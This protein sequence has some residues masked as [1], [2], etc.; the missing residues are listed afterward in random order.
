MNFYLFG[1]YWGKH[2]GRLF[3]LVLVV[4]LLTASSVFA[5]LNERSELRRQLNRL[6]DMYGNYSLVLHGVSDENLRKIEEIPNIDSLFEI[7]GI[8]SVGEVNVGDAEY[9]VGSFDSKESEKY[10]NLPLKSGHLPEKS[11]EIAVP[12]FIL[13]KISAQTD[14][15]E[16]ISLNFTDSSGKKTVLTGILSGI[17]SDNTIREDM[18]Y[19]GNS[20]GSAVVGNEVEFPTPS[21]FIYYEDVQNIAENAEKYENYILVRSD[22]SYFSDEQEKYDEIVDK[23]YEIN[24]NQSSGKQYLILSML[25]QNSGKSENLTKTH[26]KEVLSANA[27]GNANIKIIRAMSLTMM[28]ISAI[29]LISGVSAV[30]PDR[31][32]SLKLLR[33]VGMSKKKL[34]SL[35]VT[36]FMIFWIIGN[37]AGIFVG[38]LLHGVMILTEQK[39][40]IQ[41]FFGYTA[42][43]IV[44]KITISPFLMPVL[45][46]AVVAVFSAIIPVTNIFR[47]NFSGQS[48][49]RRSKRGLHSET[50]SIHGIFGKIAGNR[51]LSALSCVSIAVTICAVT[52]GYCYFTADG[53]GKTYLTIGQENSQDE[54]FRI[55]GVD[56]RK[57]DI[58]CVLESNIPYGNSIAVYDENFGVDGKSVGELENSENIE[59]LFAWGIYTAYTVVY[60][61]G[62]KNSKLGKD[63]IPISPEWEYYNNFKDIT[64]YNV[65]LLILSDSMM[66]MLCSS[67]PYKDG[68]VVMISRDGSF[69]CEI[70]EKIPAM[71]CICDKNTHVLPE[72]MR[73]FEIEIT[74]QITMRKIEKEVSEDSILRN[75]GVMSFNTGN[76]VAMT[77]ETA[78]NLG[79]YHPDY[80]CIL[81]QFAQGTSDSEM[82]ET[83]ANAT[84]KTV[85]ITTIGDMRK[86]ALLEKISATANSAVLFV[87]LFVLCLLTVWNILQMSVRNSSEKLATVHAVGMPFRKIR[88]IF[89]GNALKTVF[90]ALFL[91][92]SMTLAGRAFLSEKYDEY[93]ENLEI[94]QEMSGNED[95]PNVILNFSTSSMDKSDEL[96][97]ITEKLEKLEKN[98]MLDKELWLP[99]VLPVLAII[100]T[101]MT[102]GVLICAE[103]SAKKIEKQS[104]TE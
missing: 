56:M 80:S 76:A 69:A 99:K 101:A 20:N 86:K 60:S 10:Y 46:S 65:P 26:G 18:E 102:V 74:K 82:R 49:K 54:Y 1:K 95:F 47:M 35:F 103:T 68:D 84:G 24:G 66:E 16:E 53:K 50:S 104:E 43:Y 2:K 11:G 37:I 100:C 25:A 34:C 89:V 27:D 15:G 33:C 48:G 58:D 87:L 23:I 75:C 98:F 40:G 52:F 44:E 83:I 4:F 30:M 45:L 12:E 78:E 42:E 5:V 13:K 8:T 55:N 22:E 38:C 61:D 91:G 3:S 77:A 67:E 6:Y 9:T 70:G 79:F 29:S 96:Y 62:E 71:S 17:I 72:N 85:G 51:L 39:M 73:N 64:I 81:M 57:N 28:L 19:K 93:T 41:A 7:Y 90:L 32:K 88:R 59:N 21:L 97:P 14:T 92:I 94:Q 63:E 36:E 31:M